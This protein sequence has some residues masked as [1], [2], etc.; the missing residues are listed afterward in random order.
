[1]SGLRIMHR[2]NARHITARRLADGSI[3][4]TLPTGV[5]AESAK[6]IIMELIGK[7]TAAKTEDYVPLY[8]EYQTIGCG[9]TEITLMRQQTEPDKIIAARRNGMVSVGIGERIPLGTRETDAAISSVLIKVARFQAKSELLPRAKE[10]ARLLHAEPTGWKIGYGTKTL[11]TCR[12]DG[13]YRFR[14]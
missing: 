5:S 13:R 4:V 8:E 11:G 14:P 3:R 9:E 6:G 10:I 12:W 7:L 1:M 2:A